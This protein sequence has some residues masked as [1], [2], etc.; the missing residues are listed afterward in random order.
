MSKTNNIKGFHAFTDA[1]RD[2]ERD[3]KF[4]VNPKLPIP[5]GTVFISGGT[6]SATRT[7][8]LLETLGYRNIH[9]FGFDSS[10]SE[11]VVDKEAKDEMDNPKYLHVETGGTKFWTTGE[12]LALAQDLEKMFERK[13]LAVNIN[14]YG[15]N[16]LAA[17]VFDQSYYNQEFQTFEEFM[18]DRAA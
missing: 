14:F 15:D 6:A 18:N 16:T 8:G 13:D 17:Q 3:D 5:A 1:V 4:V 7:I 9:M 11:D 12:L 10:V 2:T